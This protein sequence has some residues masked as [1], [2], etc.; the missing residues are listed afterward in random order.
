MTEER[1]LVSSSKDMT[2]RIWATSS[3]SCLR[4]LGSHTASVTKVLWGG[5]DIVYSACQDR[6]V[7]CWDPNTG[8]LTH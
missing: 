2:V 1:R 5:E 8:I 7:R 4:V 6:I 3:N